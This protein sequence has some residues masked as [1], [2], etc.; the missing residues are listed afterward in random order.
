MA[1]GTSIPLS[2]VLDNLLLAATLLAWLLGMRFKEKMA[3]AWGN[4]V[5]RA[6]VLLFAI[7]LFGT[8][9]GAQAPGDAQSYLLKYLDLALI[10]LLG[11]FFISS[12]RR[13]IAIRLFAGGLAVV[14][15]V[16]CAL[17]VGLIP[18]LPWL[19]GT[20]E[21]PY[22]VLKLRLTHNIL[23]AYAA[24]LFAWLSRS[25]C[26]L[27]GKLAWALLCT[28][29]ILNITLVV[30][31]ATGYVLLA[32]LSL[33]FGWQ[34]GGWR[35][36]GIALLA[37]MLAIA[38]LSAFPGPFQSRINQIVS[39]AQ[40]EKAGHSASTST[41]YRLEF[42]RNT[43]TLIGDNP[44]LGSGTGSFPALYAIHVAGTG[45]A[46]SRNPHNEFLLI[47]VQ[48]G[49]VGLAAF[50]WL[51]WQQWRIA[52]QLPTRLECGLAQGLVVTMILISLLNSALLDHTEGLL[53]A[54][55]TAL[56]YAGLPASP[57]ATGS[58]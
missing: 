30:E 21:S 1:I 52:P 48:T 25:S 10:P 7:L 18:P 36:T 44:L 56:L 22:V 16:S 39:E 29:T 42:Y 35:G 12:A 55:L 24:F 5:Y 47:A 31:G 27:W 19:R 28:L 37:V 51:L 40:Q 17:K 14:M 33:L 15:L 41:G 9:Y 6:A 26:A 34:R 8:T 53:Y 54:W 50:A 11:W 58:A 3:L 23:M 46:A 38:T 45:Q 4:P 13:T 20:P 32:A 57:K 49:L 2:I 43:L